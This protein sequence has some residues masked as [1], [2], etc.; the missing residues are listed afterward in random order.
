[1]KVIVKGNGLHRSETKALSRMESELQD[2]WHAYASVLIMDQQGSMEFDLIIVTHDRVL[3]V[4]LKNWRGKL[5][6][7]DGNWYIDG[8]Y[9]SKSPY[10]TKRDQALRLKSIL[11]THLSHDLGYP[12]FVEAHVVLCGEATPDHL[13]SSEQLYVHRLDNFLKVKNT[14]VYDAIVQK[15]SLRFDGIGRQRPNHPDNLKSFDSFFRG[16]RVELAKFKVKGY[17]ADENPDHQHELKLFAEY[18]A[19][20]EESR[21]RRAIIRRWDLEVLGI[22]NREDSIWKKVISRENHL[23]N[24]ASA[25]NSLLQQYMLRPLDAPDDDNIAVDCVAMYE[26]KQ[27]TRRLSEFIALNSHKWSPDQRIDIVRALLAPFAELHSLGSAHRDIQPQ[28]LWYSEDSAYILTSG[29]HAAFIPEKGTVK[30]LSSLLRSSSTLIPEDVYGGEG[31]PVNPFAKDVYLLALVA[32]KI[33]FP[34]Q[35]LAEEEGVSIW[36]PIES[37]KFNGKLDAFFEKAMDLDYQ[38]RFANAADMLA[39]FNAISI[40]SDRSYDDTSEVIKA[41][42]AGEFINRDLNPFTLQGVFPAVPDEQV[43]FFGEKIAYRCLVNGEQCL[44]KLWQHARIDLQNPAANR[45]LLRMRRRIEKAV[46][47]K[48]PIS[49][50]VQ[51]GLFG[52]GAGLFIV[53][54]YEDGITWREY[55]STLSTLEKKLESALALCDLAI[56]VHASDF[57]HGDL[58]PDNIL[59]RGEDWGRGHTIDMLL[60]DALDYGDT[61]DPY[62]VEYGPAN[63]TATDGFGRDR[64]AV[65]RMVEELFTEH[66]SPGLAVELQAAGD[67][68]DCVPVDLALLRAALKSDLDHHVTPPKAAQPALRLM[69]NHP[70]LPEKPTLLQKEGAEYHLSVQRANDNPSLLFFTITGHEKTLR[71]KLDPETRIITTAWIKDSGLGDYASDGQRSQCS[72][73]TPITV[74]RGIMGIDKPNS[75]IE[76]LMNLDVVLDL[77]VD[78][79]EPKEDVREDESLVEG[80][81]EQTISPHQIWRALLDTEGEQR[82][83][84]ELRSVDIVESKSGAWL[85]PCVLKTGN[86]LEFPADEIEEIGVYFGDDVHAF[87]WAT[88]EETTDEVLAVKPRGESLSS[89]KKRVSEGAHL[90]LESKRSHASRFRRQKAMDRVLSGNSKVHNLPGYFDEKGDVCASVLAEVPAEAAI[91][92]RYDRRNGSDEELNPK[93]ILAFQRVV[94]QSPIAVLQGPPGTGKTAFVSKL[95]HYLFENKLANN[96]LLVGQ[97]HTSVDTVAIKAKELCQE[98][99]T[100]LSL[101]RLGREHQIDEKLLQ[102]HSSSIQSKMRFKFQRE[103]EN[104]INAL[105]CRLM[106]DQGF[107]DEIAKLHRSISPLLSN[108][109]VLLGSINELSDERELSPDRQAHVYELKEA[110]KSS[111]EHIQLNIETRGYDFDLPEITDPSYWSELTRHIAIRHG[112]SNQIAIRR[113]NQLIGISKDWIDVLASASSSFDRFFVKSSQLVAGT[114]VGMGAKWL[115]LEEQEFDWVIV[116]EAG[117]AQASELM[118]ALQCAKRVLLVGDHCQLPPFYEQVHI[119]H[120]ARLLGINEAEV[121]K[122]DFERAF[123]V[124]AGLTLDTQYR[125]IEPIGEIISNC[126]YESKLQ[127]H[128]KKAPEWCRDLPYPLN[129]PVT[130][131]DSGSGARAVDED[132]DGK[133]AV[134]NR[135]EY[136][137]CRDILRQLARSE[138]L[139]RLRAKKTEKHPF[140]I[141]IIVMYRAQ[142]KLLENELSKAEWAAPIRD[143]IKIET[144]DAYQG[145]ENT[146]IILSLVRNNPEGKQGF[147]VEASRINVALSRAQERLVVI[148]SKHMWERSNANSSL[149]DVLAFISE[150]SA[151]G[152]EN[153]EFVDGTTVIEAAK[154][155]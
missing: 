129:K 131:I 25:T 61:S 136:E 107:V 69:H 143:L 4:E 67:Q 116:D 102:C 98:L 133:G 26:V 90:F 97:S 18:P 152:N 53:T 5:T 20:H 9:R 3:V 93:Q 64:F 39:E 71:L 88:A 76:F 110:L 83:K 56:H 60:I 135:H 122:T 103:Y 150:K 75:F 128:R 62:N 94:S 95:I 115:S 22:L 73:T 109:A 146:I 55:V 127:S 41:L 17:E 59:V 35:K 149:A 15:V 50:V 101:V 140:P 7:Y 24:N 36:K 154:Y 126:F 54:R 123:I 105:A 47:A 106:L 8:N 70:H 142:K 23:Y 48:L 29:Y 65:Y 38:N 1:M 27:N 13:P 6:S 42:S 148:G 63:P 151:E 51:Y 57:A 30:E 43:S 111:K 118:I 125:M 92:A 113:L 78:M 96:I 145:Q 34:N 40:G 32:H 124:N 121:R 12:P 84:L 74:E 89:F 87:G 46:E 117:R 139:E 104:R 91:R 108:I 114:L 82:Q 119:R 153:Y 16:R 45:R 79:F 141:G 137:V 99:D 100:P 120:V 11:Q 72:F 81:I 58:H 33:C 44:L 31:E 155:A 130:W 147:L 132:N 19:T 138:S 86:E 14:T 10:H 144:V 2:S 85:M 21:V 80:S 28:N 77:L 37:D 134:T 49:P 112:V 52:E 68:P 66:I